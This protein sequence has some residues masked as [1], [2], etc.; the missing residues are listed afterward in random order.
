[1]LCV[2]V[3][4]YASMPETHKSVNYAG[5]V[6]HRVEQNTQNTLIPTKASF[7]QIAAKNVIAWETA[8]ADH[9]YIYI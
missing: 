2:C 9:I 8:Q 7:S 5:K 3:Y 4:M 6:I 1:M